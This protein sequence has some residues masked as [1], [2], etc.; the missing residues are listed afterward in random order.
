ML[1]MKYN[2]YIQANI[3]SYQATANPSQVAKMPTIVGLSRM[4]TI[5]AFSMLFKKTLPIHAPTIPPTIPIYQDHALI[6]K[7][8]QSLV[9]AV[10][11]CPSLPT[12][13]AKNPQMV[14]GKKAV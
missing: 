11:G 3:Y 6:H 13:P 10:N 1:E 14:S 8:V 9:S 7:R 2:T 5:P 12:I 4:N